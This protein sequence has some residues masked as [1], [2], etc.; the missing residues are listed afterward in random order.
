MVIKAVVSDGW[1]SGKGGS[2]WWLEY[3]LKW[4]S[5]VV[6]MVVELDEVFIGSGR[7][8]NQTLLKW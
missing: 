7:S 6:G 3:L 4:Y 5:V 2:F 1:N 8:C